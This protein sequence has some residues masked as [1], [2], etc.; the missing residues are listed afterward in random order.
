[1]SKKI[2]T[3]QSS[4][5][6]EFDKM[7]KSF[8]L[9]VS[10]MLSIG[11]SQYQEVIDA[12]EA[13]EAIPQEPPKAEEIMN[14]F[15]LTRPD[16]DNTEELKR[17]RNKFNE[18]KIIQSGLKKMRED[19][20]G[21]STMGGVLDLFTDE[22]GHVLFVH[23]EVLGEWLRS[24][25]EY[26][27][28]NDSLFLIHSVKSYYKYT[29]YWARYDQDD[30]IGAYYAEQFYFHNDSLII[31]LHEEGEERSDSEWFKK[32]QKRMLAKS[33]EL[34]HRYHD[35]DG[36]SDGKYWQPELYTPLGE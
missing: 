18:L 1:M 19:W 25:E 13:L 23:A 27:Y 36:E 2:Y 20:G 4:D 26:Y 6:K 28:H 15:I 17:I 31:W 10:L 7:K 29:G 21:M 8:I 3:I 14:Q 34:L 11:Y 12:L 5:K 16:D 32:K 35:T 9:I 22:N 30:E 24:D 33:Q